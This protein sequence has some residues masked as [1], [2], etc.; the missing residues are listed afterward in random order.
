M[1][2]GCIDIPGC[3]YLG[4]GNVMREEGDLLQMKE[5]RDLSC[6]KSRLKLQP[7]EVWDIAVEA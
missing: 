4:D 6:Q 3:G 1:D 5:T 7:G 2:L